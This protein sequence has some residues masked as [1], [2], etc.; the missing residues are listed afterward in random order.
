M[1]RESLTDYI[2]TLSPLPTV[3]ASQDAALAPEAART[4]PI[5]AL[6]IE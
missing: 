1:F 5:I 2:H 6:T 4:S 3:R